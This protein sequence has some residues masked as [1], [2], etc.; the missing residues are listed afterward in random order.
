MAVNVGAAN[1]V[2]ADVRDALL[3]YFDAVLLAEPLQAALWRSAGITLTQLAAL[4]ELRRRP[5]PAGRLGR[6]VGL[7][8]ASVTHLLDRLEE[9]GLAVRRRC[10]DD[11]RTVTVHLTEDGQRTLGESKIL[12]GSRVHQAIDAMSPERRR[13]LAAALADLVAEVKRLQPETEAPR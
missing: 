6:L 12:V 13:R 10:D 4:R 9:R 7:S 3:A 5:L 2:E 11:R 8:P 1:P